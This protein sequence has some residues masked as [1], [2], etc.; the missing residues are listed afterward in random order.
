M[1]RITFSTLP[2]PE[3]IR[4]LNA[5]RLR[6][7]ARE[8]GHRLACDPDNDRLAELYNDILERLHAVDSA[9]KPQR[10]EI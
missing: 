10:G 4:N 9:G 7:R 5:D 1:P 2:A 8:L 3:N 6:A